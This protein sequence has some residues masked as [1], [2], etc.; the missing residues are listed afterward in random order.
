MANKESVIQNPYA[1]A[2]SRAAA[3]KIIMTPRIINIVRVARGLG[4]F[5]TVGGSSF[6][7]GR[8]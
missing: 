2:A 5:L 4:S 8:N 3:T 1:C 7:P 6:S